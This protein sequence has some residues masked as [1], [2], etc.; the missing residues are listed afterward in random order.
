MK[1]SAEI[2]CQVYVIQDMMS[3]FHFLFLR[4]VEYVNIQYLFFIL[5]LNDILIFNRCFFL[6]KT[7]Q[8]FRIQLED[9]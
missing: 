8:F 6:C 4:F 7:N 9:D 3:L 1:P 5:E 2:A